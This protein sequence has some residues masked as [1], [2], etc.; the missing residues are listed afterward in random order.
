MNC[1]CKLK[2]AVEQKMSHT[3]NLKRIRKD[4]ILREKIRLS[5]QLCKL[6]MIY[7]R[8]DDYVL[9]S[10]DCVLFFG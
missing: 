6:D 7:R 9:A 3:L 2:V 1:W 4:Q 5:S 10:L 8:L